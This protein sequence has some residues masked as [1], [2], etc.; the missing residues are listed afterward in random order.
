MNRPLATSLDDKVNLQDCLEPGR[1]A[2]YNKVRTI[3]TKSN[4]IRQGKMGS[5]P[6]DF[7]GKED[8]LWCTEME[9]IFGFPKH[10]TDVNNMGRSQRQKV[11]GRS[12]SVPV[13]RHLFAPLKDYFACDQAV[14]NMVSCSP[15]CLVFS[16]HSLITP[17]KAFDHVRDEK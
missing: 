4:S 9:K 1:T 8:Y 12:W 7:N 10:Y 16:C 2:K 11:L 5:L 3:T 17:C 13:I 6:V 15:A 14:Y